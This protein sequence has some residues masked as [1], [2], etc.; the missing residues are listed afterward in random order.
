[1]EFS[2]TKK[3]LAGEI[4]SGRIAGACALV[5][6]DGDPVFCD[7]EGYT[8]ADGKIKISENSAFRLASMTKPITATA[9]LLCA[10]KGL[11]GLSRK[12]RDFIPGT[13]DLYVAEKRN[14]EWVKGEK[15]DDVTLFQLLTHSSGVGC[16]EIE[17]TEFAKVK[18]GEGDTLA[19]AT[20]R[21]GKALLAFRPGTAQAYS[22]VMGFD[23]LARVVEVVS[24]IS[25][26]EFL[27][28]EIFAP[29]RMNFSSYLLSDFRREDLV[30]SCSYENGVLNG[31]L[32]ETNF[33]DFPVGYTGGSAG[34]VSTLG[35][36]GRFA[37]ELL[38]C[39]RG[40]EGILS[41]ESAVMMGTPQLDEKK[42]PGVY[43]FFNWGLG[44]R[45]MRVC[46]DW[47]P[48]PAGSYGWSG[49]Y[50][51]HFWVDPENGVTAV[52]MHNSATF[53]GAGAP[54]TLAF[55]RAVTED[56]SISR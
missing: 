13:G 8:G 51:T 43:D 54:H 16:G 14:G 56:L 34:L 5:C 3:M 20:A 47:Q 55:E 25:Y 11:L 26:G 49:A 22:P 12:V 33:G 50:G 7:Y 42:I 24:G 40:G 44:V 1:M 39:Y 27:K 9:V 10:E 52:Y 37:N 30:S 45:A 23:L 38:R 32:P 28:R 19:T 29:L 41:R 15:A 31:S 6:K 18:P 21:Y 48:L 17:S 2:R 4:A 36:Y 53:G 46:R 35:D